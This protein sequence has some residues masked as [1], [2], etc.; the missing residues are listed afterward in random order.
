MAKTQFSVAKTGFCQ[1]Q[2]THGIL[3]VGKNN[4]FIIINALHYIYQERFSPQRKGRIAAEEEQPPQ[5]GALA[6]TNSDDDEDDRLPMTTTKRRKNHTQSA[7]WQ[8]LLLMRA[9]RRKHNRK[10]VPWKETKSVKR[11]LLR[12]D[13]LER[14][15]YCL[16]FL[17][18]KT[19][20]CTFLAQIYFCH[21]EAKVPGKSAKFGKILFLP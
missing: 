8:L 5:A 6:T 12:E 1:S 19:K 4:L 3:Q 17:P 2:S 13:C 20:G 9:K 21:F 10:P 15:H 7:P 11:G 16:A 14:W 18:G